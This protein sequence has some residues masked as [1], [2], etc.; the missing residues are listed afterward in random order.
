M[1][2]DGERP[3]D[4]FR[5]VSQKTET[6]SVERF[7]RVGEQL[8]LRNATEGGEEPDSQKEVPGRLLSSNGEEVDLID[9]LWLYGK[10][11]LDNRMGQLDVRAALRRIQ[12]PAT[13]RIHG[14]TIV[15]MLKRLN[16]EMTED[17]LEE[18]YTEVFGRAYPDSFGVDELAYIVDLF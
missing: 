3:E 4:I 11:G 16:V 15:A 1:H 7:L 9:F 14:D 2:G 10:L 8:A 17:E 12:N 13:K 5:H 18:L 6:I